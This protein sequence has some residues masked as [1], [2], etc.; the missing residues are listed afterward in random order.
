MSKC[1]FLVLLTVRALERI[2][3]FIA[4]LLI[5]CRIVTAIGEPELTLGTLLCGCQSLKPP[6]YDIRILV[7]RFHVCKKVLAFGSL[8]LF[9]GLAT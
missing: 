4:R 7:T 1:H 8:A 5:M 3:T 9:K 6:E 2:I